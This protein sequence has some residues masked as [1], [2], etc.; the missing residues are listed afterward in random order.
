[1]LA[2]L[3]FCLIVVGM[4]FSLWMVV[5]VIHESMVAHRERFSRRY[6]SA[7]QI[8]APAKA[9]IAQAG[10]TFRLPWRPKLEH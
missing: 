9:A 3:C 8:R 7:A 6:P 4:A 10:R 5:H 1:V 2:W